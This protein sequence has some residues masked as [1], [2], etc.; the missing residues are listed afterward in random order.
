MGGVLLSSIQGN[1]PYYIS[2][3][4]I[5]VYSIE[6]IS[7]LLYNHI[8]L[9]SDDFFNQELVEY[10][11]NE[12]RLHKLADSLSKLIK[13]NASY[14]EMLILVL[15]ESDY[16][17]YD[18][19]K[20]IQT[21][22][23]KINI[24]SLHSRLKARGDL[25]Y[26]KDKYYRAIKIYKKILEEIPEADLTDEFYANTLNNLG[27]IYAKL[28]LYE[29]S[30]KCFKSAY[31]LY[32]NEIYLKRIV[33]INIINNNEVNLLNNIK[34]YDISYD[35]LKECRMNY[36]KECEDVENHEEYIRLNGLLS[37]DKFDANLYN[38]SLQETVEKW[39]TEYRELI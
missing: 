32:N 12:L 31:E 16:Y 19:I 36:L 26:K 17:N 30:E 29:D 11:D 13:E 6:E 33:L 7:Y 18:E 10:L 37:C 15:K 4:D 22:I 34:K 23:Q 20:D 1:N 25:F 8:Y 38:I 35:I 24:N 5:N 28:F 3:I 2:D 21:E 9:L 39:K 27:V 14:E